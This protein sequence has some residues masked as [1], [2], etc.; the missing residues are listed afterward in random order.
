MICRAPCN[1]RKPD[2]NRWR[3]VVT[4]SRRICKKYAVES[5]CFVLFHDSLSQTARNR[6]RGGNAG[7]PAVTCA[8][9]FRAARSDTV[10]ADEETIGRVFGC[11]KAFSV[12][13]FP[14]PRVPTLRV[15]GVVLTVLAM[16]RYAL[17]VLFPRPPSRGSRDGG[18][19]CRKRGWFPGSGAGEVRSGNEREIQGD[20]VPSGVWGCFASYEI[21][22]GPADMFAGFERI[23]YL[24]L[25][26]CPGAPCPAVLRR[27]N[28][29]PA[30]GRGIK[31]RVRK[32]RYG[33]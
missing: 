6:A 10:V 32:E 33:L 27:I 12:F 28:G 19:R 15:Q 4:R 13:R 29:P 31:N 23:H 9:S 30:R 22:A 24:C 3:G 5:S 18:Q 14:E 20:A 1:D 21:P 16:S 26:A 7:A 8:R 17:P 11:S 2:F 25:R